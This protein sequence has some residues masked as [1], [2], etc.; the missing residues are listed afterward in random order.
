MN[1]IGNTTLLRSIAK[2]VIPPMV[3]FLMVIVAWE[4]L[5]DQ[6]QVPKF[7]L[8][9]PSAVA[10]A[11]WNFGPELRTGLAFTGAAAITGFLA[12]LFVGTLIPLGVAFAGGSAWAWAQ[13]SLKL[14]VPWAIWLG[15]T[16]A[17]YRQWRRG[18][19]WGSL[20]AAAVP[21]LLMLGFALA[22]R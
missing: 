13:A 14:M 5:V 15:C 11:A 9:S 12:S 6:L 8:P 1:G 16:F 2:K 18:S 3:L 21:P 10:K 22:M 17:V 20:A 7:I 19:D 4:I